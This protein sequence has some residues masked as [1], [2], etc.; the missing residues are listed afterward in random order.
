MSKS[1]DKSIRGRPFVKGQIANPRGRPTGLPDRRTQ[2]RELIEGRMP[3][4][5]ERCVSLALQG[6]VQ[7][8]RLCLERVLPAVRHGDEL[9]VLPFDQAD[10]MGAQAR[11]VIQAVFNG[12]ISPSTA[13]TLMTTIAG[14]AHAIEI[15][16]LAKRVEALETALVAP[17]DDGR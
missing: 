5:I 1:S 15:D 9:V 14:Q 17:R 6:D 11:N 3:E 7:A 12:Q 8:L 4:L 16:E 13:S 2:Y 10:A